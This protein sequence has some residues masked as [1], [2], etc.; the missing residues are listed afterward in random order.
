MP[1]QALVDIERGHCLYVHQ[2]EEPGEERVQ[3]VI[4]FGG[5]DRRPH[6]EADIFFFVH[7][8]I[9]G[10]FVTDVLQFLPVVRVF[11][12]GDG[13]DDG[14]IIHLYGDDME[15]GRQFGFILVYEA[16]QESQRTVVASVEHIGPLAVPAASIH[17][18]AGTGQIPGPFFR[19]GSAV[20]EHSLGINSFFDPAQGIVHHSEPGGRGEEV[21]R[22]HIIQGG[23]RLAQPSFYFFFFF[24]YRERVLYYLGDLD[25]V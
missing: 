18:G 16:F 23:V 20:D 17:K 25:H 7:P 5:V 21:Q 13:V 22:L 24:E 11:M 15:M 19:L 3:Q 8:F 4:V 14:C 9:A 10:E 6:A 2:V 1:D 12:I